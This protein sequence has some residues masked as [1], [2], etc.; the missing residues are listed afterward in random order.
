MSNKQIFLLDGIGALL[1]TI[2]LGFILV[3]FQS[4]IGMPVTVLYSLAS[5]ALLFA[6]Y[7]L[8]THFLQPKRWRGYLKI[9]AGANLLYCLTTLFLVIYYFDLLTYWGIG[10]FI[11]EIIILLF[12]VRLELNLVQR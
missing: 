5:I 12:L 3:E 4:F 7:S 11:T 6:L 8:S 9:I 2:L 10:Y 1:S